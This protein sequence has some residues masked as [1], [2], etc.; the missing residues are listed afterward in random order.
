MEEGFAPIVIRWRRTKATLMVCDPKDRVERPGGE[1]GT[2]HSDEAG[3]T[4]CYPDQQ[5]LV[6]GGLYWSAVDGDRASPAGLERDA[7]MD[8]HSVLWD[9]GND[10]P[11][12]RTKI[13]FPFLHC[14]L[15]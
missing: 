10:P 12:F 4:G 3:R 7:L 6:E 2:I 8:G 9:H 5:T 15:V 14:H 11:D 1:C 13:C